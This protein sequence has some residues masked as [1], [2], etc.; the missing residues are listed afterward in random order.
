[1]PDLVSIAWRLHRYGERGVDMEKLVLV[2]SLPLASV[3][4]YDSVR[5][6]SVRR[7]RG[8]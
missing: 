8:R 2:V 1:V 3:N 5:G 6:V 4:S 7:V